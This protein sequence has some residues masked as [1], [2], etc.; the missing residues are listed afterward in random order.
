MLEGYEINKLAKQVLFFIA[1]II[2]E[3]G[4]IFWPILFIAVTYLLI[5]KVRNKA[6]SY[7]LSMVIWSVL[8]ASGLI[9]A[10]LNAILIM[11]AKDVGGI[12]F[13]CN[14]FSC[15]TSLYCISNISDFSKTKSG[16]TW[17]TLNPQLN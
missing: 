1:Y 17:R 2:S 15:N 4:L 12:N 11:N 6:W 13:L 8:V 3:L 16:H 5:R 10:L 7:G 14:I 9:T